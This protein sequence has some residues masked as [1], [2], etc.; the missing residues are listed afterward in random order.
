MFVAVVGYS[1]IPLFI[2]WGGTESPFIFN[3]AWRVGMPIGCLVV[4]VLAYRPL[5]LRKDVWSL[6]WQRI[7]SLPM[8]FWVFNSFHLVFYAW[9]TQFIDVAISAVLYETWPILLVLLT[10]WLFR[11]EERYRKLSARTGILF[12]FAF[13]GVTSV[14]ASQSGGLSNLQEHTLPTLGLGVAIVIV[15]AVLKSLAA[16]GFR[17]GTELAARFPDQNQYRTSSIE[18]FGVVVGIVICNLLTLPITAAAGFARDEPVSIEA[19][20]F[21]AVGGAILGTFA[22]FF[23]RKANLMTHDLSINAMAYVTPVLSLVL[24]FMFSLVGDINVGYLFLGTAAIVIANVGIYLEMGDSQ[25][26]SSERSAHLNVNSLIASGESDALEFKSTLRLDL[27]T[28]KPERRIEQAALK[29]L[30][31]FL[32]TNGGTL[33]IG[34]SDNHKPVGV[35]ADGFPDEDKMSLHLRNIVNQRMGPA[36]MSLIHSSFHDFEGVRIMVLRCDSSTQPVFV[37]EGQNAESF[38]IRTGPST[39]QLS[40]SEAN[41]YINDRF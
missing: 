5:L 36:T 17:W 15:A 21:G 30:A 29:S 12:V 7:G 23:W 32:N 25:G 26:Q 38:Y 27:R 19:M 14:I 20:A 34:V 1:L 41:S 24:L 40:I 13:L 16:F 22:S 39:T 11:S 28:K 8:L 18:L 4:L 2:A 10:A 31:A 3:T 6:V 9:S 37:D 33:V 35:H